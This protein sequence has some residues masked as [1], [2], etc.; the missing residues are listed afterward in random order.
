MGEIKAK[1]AELV[2]TRKEMKKRLNRALIK[3]EHLEKRLE[4]SK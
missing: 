4:F 3:I 1:F 2:F